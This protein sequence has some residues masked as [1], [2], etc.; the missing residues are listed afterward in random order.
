[1]KLILLFSAV[2]LIALSGCADASSPPKPDLPASVSPGWTLKSF[3]DSSAPDGLPEGPKPTCWKANY[4]GANQATAE[5]WVCGFTVT[6]GAFDAGQR[7]R[8]AANT[9]KFDKGRYLVVARWN[10][11]SRTDV[12][13]LMRALQAALK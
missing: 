7:T 3:D 4:T 11:G 2:S 9:V 8:A 13:A 1:M 5:A 12:V 10:N 6:S